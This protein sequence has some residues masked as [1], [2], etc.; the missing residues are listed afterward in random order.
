MSHHLPCKAG[1]VTELA[2]HTA[3]SGIF[4]TLGK[5]WFSFTLSHKGAAWRSHPREGPYRVDGEFRWLKGN[6]S[7]LSPSFVLLW[8]YVL[9][10]GN[11]GDFNYL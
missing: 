10:L 8:P 1:T 5:A 7:C 11:T 3:I 6:Y 2:A 9:E 4:V